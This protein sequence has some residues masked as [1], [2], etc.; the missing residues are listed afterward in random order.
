MNPK[1]SLVEAG[2]PTGFEVDRPISGTDRTMFWVLARSMD[3]KA[4]DGKVYGLSQRIERELALKTITVWGAYY[5]MKEGAIGSLSP[6]KA[7]DF[8]VLDRDYLTVAE[9]DIEKLRVLMTVVGGRIVHLVPSL[10]KVVGLKAQGAQ[11]ELGGEAA[12]W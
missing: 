8:V 6:G 11:V 5:L 10:A 2:I 12:A 1:K 3:R 4:A 9:V 7:A